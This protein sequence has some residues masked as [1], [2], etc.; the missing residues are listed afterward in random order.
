MPKPFLDVFLSGLRFVGDTELSPSILA[1]CDDHGR[2]DIE[3]SLCHTRGLAVGSNCSISEICKDIA[4]TQL[5]G[6]YQRISCL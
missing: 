4:I 1:F 6:D 2:K 5:I 3:W